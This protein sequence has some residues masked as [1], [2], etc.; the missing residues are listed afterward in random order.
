MSK[1]F[2]KNK[3]QRL[4]TP[5]KNPTNQRKKIRMTAF[6]QRTTSIKVILKK[7]ENK[8]PINIFKTCSMSLVI[9][10]MQTKTA[11]RFHLTPVI[12]VDIKKVIH[13]IV[14]TYSNECWKE[15]ERKTLVH[16]WECQHVTM[17]MLIW[18]F[19]ENS[20]PNYYVTHIYMLG[21]IEGTVSAP[22]IYTYTSM[23]SGVL[24]MMAK[25]WEL[26]GCP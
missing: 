18:K 20:K 5:H 26:P 25:K 4:L 9:K 13:S 21:F 1:L 16:W 6:C 15:Y 19:R 2:E 7:K 17:R 3:S 12:M 11:L 23:F 10:K 14:P 8:G 22:H 24:V